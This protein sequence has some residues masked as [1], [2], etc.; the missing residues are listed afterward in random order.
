MAVTSK[1][2]ADIGNSNTGIP[3]RTW[4]HVRD[5][6][7]FLRIITCGVVRVTKMTASSSD[8]WIY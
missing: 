2:I 8:D 3:P 1:T 6:L 5:P 7:C 4:L